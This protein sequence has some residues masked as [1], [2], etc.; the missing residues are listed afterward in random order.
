MSSSFWDADV[1]H[2]YSTTDNLFWASWKAKVRAWWKVMLLVQLLCNERGYFSPLIQQMPRFFFGSPILTS[3]C[4]SQISSDISF[5]KAESGQSLGLGKRVQAKQLSSVPQLEGDV[6]IA[7][8]CLVCRGLAVWFVR[9][10]CVFPLKIK[11]VIS[12]CQGFPRNPPC[13]PACCLLLLNE[14]NFLTC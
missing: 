3:L 8:L 1:H 12:G 14:D 11:C 10:R 9:Y 13:L 2:I 5:S 6:V 7:H 4:C